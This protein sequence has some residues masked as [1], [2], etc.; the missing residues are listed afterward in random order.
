M[1]EAGLMPQRPWHS[2]QS[3]GEVMDGADDCDEQKGFFPGNDGKGLPQ[4]GSTAVVDCG[5]SSSPRAPDTLPRRDKLAGPTT[6]E[7]THTANDAQNELRGRTSAGGR[8]RASEGQCGVC[9]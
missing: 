1:A 2:R 9:R 3:D 8:A 6:H 4:G 5:K 7:R